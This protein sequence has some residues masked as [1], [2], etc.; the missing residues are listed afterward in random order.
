MSERLQR[1]LLW[2]LAL[3]LV[4]GTG[5]A[6]KYVR[7]YRPVAGYAFVNPSELPGD[8]ALRFENVRAVG[9]SNNQRAWVLTAK[10]IDTTRTRSRIDFSGGVEATLLDQGVPRAVFHAPQATFDSGA[11]L[12]VAA[13]QIDCT[14]R[15]AKS[16][17]GPQIGDA[18][19]PLHFETTQVIWNVGS[20]TVMCPG[21]VE[22]E[23]PGLQVRGVNLTVDLRTRE[24]SLKQFQATMTLNDDASS[25]LPRT[26]KGL[27]P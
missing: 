25:D 13:G 14:V 22:V 24:H 19:K 9:R 18:G 6:L 5:L 20:R 2:F 8:I 16:G 4:L 1:Y 12:L 10:R 23:T 21:T 11:K 27:I 17:G 3:T 7:G 15:P 26:L